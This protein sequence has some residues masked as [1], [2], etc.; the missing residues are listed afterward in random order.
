MRIRDHLN[1]ADHIEKTLCNHMDQNEDYELFVEGYMLAGTNVMNAMIHKLGLLPESCDLLHSFKPEVHIV[2]SPE[3]TKVKALMAEIESMRD[4]Y[5][6]GN[7]TWNPE[8]GAICIRNY[9]E[10]KKLSTF[11]RGTK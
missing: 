1:H 6:R 11:Y 3:L 9:G 8:D 7:K 2:C 10:I 4:G 5:L